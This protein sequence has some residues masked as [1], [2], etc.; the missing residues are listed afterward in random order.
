[1]E[2]I[3]FADYG[4][5]IGGSGAASLLGGISPFLRVSHIGQIL[6]AFTKCG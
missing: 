2:E 4:D 1:M 5:V 6:G 3:S